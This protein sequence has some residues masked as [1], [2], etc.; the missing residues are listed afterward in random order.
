MWSSEIIED[1]KI[2]QM[3]NI[4]TVKLYYYWSKKNRT[5]KSK[6]Q[7]EKKKKRLISL[8]VKFREENHLSTCDPRRNFVP[9][10][11]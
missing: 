6:I 11:S 7:E 2:R 4:Y 3:K 5:N 10:D 1:R 9:L 8:S